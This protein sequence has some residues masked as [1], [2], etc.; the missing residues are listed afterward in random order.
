MALYNYV[1]DANTCVDPFGLTDTYIFTDGTDWYI[2][3]G[4]KVVCIL[5]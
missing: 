5:Q 1:H 2:G 3:K 4:A